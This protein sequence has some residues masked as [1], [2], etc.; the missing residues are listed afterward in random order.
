[1]NHTG[2]MHNLLLKKLESTSL[3][4]KW[5]AGDFKTFVPCHHGYL[6]AEA[7]ALA[8]S[9]SSDTASSFKE[10]NLFGLGCMSTLTSTVQVR[11]HSPGK[12]SRA[13]I[14]INFRPE[15]LQG[16]YLKN[17]GVLSVSLVLPDSETGSDG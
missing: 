12:S 4:S 13:L 3:S 6:K 10:Y 8:T 1:M 2:K 9:S 5:E 15:T 17:E 16:G 11:I 14:M 7:M